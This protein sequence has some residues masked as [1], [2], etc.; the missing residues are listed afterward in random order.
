[1]TDQLRMDLGHRTQPEAA[2]RLMAAAVTSFAERG[3]HATTTRDI[4]SAAGMSPAAMYVH[5]PSKA[6]LL[7]AIS[8]TGHRKA[9]DLV[10][11]V[12]ARD[13]PAAKRMHDLVAEFT[14]WHAQQHLVARVVQYELHA[15]PDEDFAVVAELRRETERLVRELITD[16]IASGAFDVDDVKGAARAVLSLAIDIARWYP[17]AAGPAP[18]ELGQGYAALVL[19]MLGAGDRCE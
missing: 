17:H 3:Y 11:S 5:F 16:G 12:V 2:R 15:L 18:E 9:L 13:E 19:R 1:M 14:C 10:R 7:S 6:A 8:R 4:A